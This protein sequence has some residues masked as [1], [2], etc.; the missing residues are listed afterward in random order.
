MDTKPIQDIEQI[1]NDAADL[2]LGEHLKK[3]VAPG[4]VVF[5]VGANRGQF[6]EF[7]S[8]RVP[9]LQFFCFEPVPQAY[10][11]LTQKFAG[12]S[13]ITMLPYAL[14]NTSGT[15]SL[16]VTESDVGSSLLTPTAGQ[17]SRWLSPVTHL[18]VQTMRIDD[19]LKQHQ[20]S[21]ID[22]LKIDVQGFDLPVLE[23]AGNFLSPNFIRNILIEVNF[24]NFYEGQ[25]SFGDIYNA[26][27]L[28]SGYDMKALYPHR[29]R[30]GWL[31]WAD[32]LFF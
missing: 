19:F 7:L 28:S 26:L 32:A 24:A 15:A 21:K 23:S 6:V 17:T 27:C 3:L 10:E 11:E 16:T 14:S 2:A 25:S 30:E 20:I 4:D 18:E 22:L 13:S 31:W 9:N 8:Q 12:E 5:D 1:D 29:T